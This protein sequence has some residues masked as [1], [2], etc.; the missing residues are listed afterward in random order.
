MY[1]PKTIVIMR[2]AEYYWNAAYHCDFQFKSLDDVPKEIV[3]V[4]ERRVP[5]T[6]G[7]KGQARITGKALSLEYPRGFDA[8]IYSP[9]LRV[10]QTLDE[11]LPEWK[12]PRVN[13]RIINRMRPENLLAEQNQGDGVQ[14]LDPQDRES[15]PD[16]FE[17]LRLL[18]RDKHRDAKMFRRKGIQFNGNNWDPS[19]TGES[20]FDLAIRTGRFLQR[21]FQRHYHRTTILVVTHLATKMW[22]RA[23][24]LDL[25]PEKVI[26]DL[27]SGEAAISNCGVS[28]FDFVTGLPN[29]E[30]KGDRWVCTYWNKTHYDGAYAET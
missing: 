26:D 7:G 10:E 27:N 13:R 12:D 19:M 20:H 5:L 24:L 22:L 30:E 8:I 15:W 6:P 21:L 29:K 9:W 18:L 4:E 28:R 11:M 16:Q 17:R 14:W 25:S 2:H 1:R 3:G 23:S